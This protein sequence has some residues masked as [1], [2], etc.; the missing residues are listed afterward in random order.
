M[1]LHGAYFRVI[2]EGDGTASAALSPEK[3]RLVV[4]ERIAQGGTRTIAPLLEREGRW[5]FH[6]HMLSHMSAEYRY[7]EPGGGGD[8]QPA[9][10]MHHAALDS[11]GMAGLVLGLTV[12]PV[13]RPAS[14]AASNGPARKLRLLVRQ[15]PGN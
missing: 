2:G 4:T 15:R 6:C 13:V 12:Q 9:V 7:V 1:H 10:G 14:P 5:L 11:T 8:F 3:Q